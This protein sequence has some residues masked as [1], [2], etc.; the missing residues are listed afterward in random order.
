MHYLVLTK[1]GISS[2]AYYASLD[3][4]RDENSLRTIMV[5]LFFSSLCFH[6]SCLLIHLCS[7]SNHVS[8]FWGLGPRKRSLESDSKLYKIVRELLATSDPK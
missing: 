5:L 3:L 7:L 4:S 1:V 6:C 8:R 2:P